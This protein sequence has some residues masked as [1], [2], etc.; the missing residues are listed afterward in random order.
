MSHVD[1]KKCQSRMSLSLISPNS[2]CRIQEKAMPRVAIFLSAMSHVTEPH[3]SYMS[4][5][6]NTHVALSIFGVKGH[7]QE[8]GGW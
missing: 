3:V 7:S 1:F 5:L 4:N 8:W 6:R 2:T